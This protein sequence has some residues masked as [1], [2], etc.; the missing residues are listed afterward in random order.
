MQDMYNINGMYCALGDVLAI[1]YMLEHTTSV[2]TINC[3]AIMI[4]NLSFT[5]YA[6]LRSQKHHRF[7][8]ISLSP[9][10]W[11]EMRSRWRD[12][13]RERIP[14]HLKKELR[15]WSTGSTV[16]NQLWRYYD[17]TIHIILNWLIILDA[18]SIRIISWSLNCVR[19]S[20]DF[21]SAGIHLIEDGL[22]HMR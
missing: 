5:V 9:P 8:H 6:N 1:W 11:D 10:A 21:K 13:D 22:I 2:L 14:L 18:A 3:T 12:I 16:S 17:I 19:N 7:S 15:T 4:L 20:P